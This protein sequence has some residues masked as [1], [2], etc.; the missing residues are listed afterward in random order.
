MST[1]QTVAQRIAE[2]VRAAVAPREVW[3]RESEKETTATLYDPESGRT[4]GRVCV[5]RTGRASQLGITLD[6][7]GL[8]DDSATLA[9]HAPFLSVYVS[10]QSRWFDGLPTRLGFKPWHSVKYGAQLYSMGDDDVV[11]TYAWAH[12]DHDSQYTW[13]KPFRHGYFNLADVV[14]GSVRHE[15]RELWRGAVSIPMPEGVYVGEGSLTEHTHRRPRWPG[16]WR[17][18]FRDNVDV[19][20]G[21]EHPGKH[22]ATHGLSPAGRSYRGPNGAFDAVGGLVAGVMKDRGGDA[23]WRPETRVRRRLPL[24]DEGPWEMRDMLTGEWRETSALAIAA[25]R[26]RGLRVDEHP[27]GCCGAAYG[28]PCVPYHGDACPNLTLRAE[29]PEYRASDPATADA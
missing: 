28:A 14:F 11:F 29:N 6:A 5:A 15:R 7:G 23:S 4:Q 1:K 10:W 18:F 24:C 16:A 9:L 20:Q 12:N 26:G 2:V 19:P 17:R 22:G 25:L 8:H 27:C 13:H 21:I 3:L